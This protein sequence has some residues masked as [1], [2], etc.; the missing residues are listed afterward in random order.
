M[1]SDVNMYDCTPCPKCGS[2]F[3]YPTQAV[4]PKHPSAVICDDCGHVEPQGPD[5]YRP[6]R[7]EESES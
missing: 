6:T 4:H 5:S 3:R 2:R 1:T 7:S